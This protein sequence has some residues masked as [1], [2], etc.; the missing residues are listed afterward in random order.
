MQEAPIVLIPA[1]KPGDQFI[2]L[3]HAIMQSGLRVLVVDDGGGDAY[4]AL[5]DE[6]QTLGCTVLRHE[7]NYGKGRALKTGMQAATEL[8]KES[9]GI[10]TADA[11][12]QHTVPDILRIADAMQQHA[13]ALI[14][15]VRLFTG[16]VPLRSRVGNAITRVVTRAISGIRCRD[17]QTGLRGIPMHA[18]PGMLS[19]QGDRYEY[20]MSMLLH[21]RELSLS[22]YEVIIETVYIDDNSG[23]HFHAVRDGARIYAVIFRYFFRFFLSSLISFAVDYALYL[24]L[25]YATHL[26]VAASYAIARAVSSLVNYTINRAVVFK[27]HGGKWSIVRYYAL[28]L[29]LMGA[30]A[31]LADVLNHLL[32]LSPSIIKPLIDFA[33]FF[34]SFTVQ[35]VFV[36]GD[37]KSSPE[38]KP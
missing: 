18:V 31:G 25:L 14:I 10:V 15:G 36:F 21:A 1:Y 29:L 2:P 5:F 38:T 3:C 32:P 24:L 12:G 22:I 28:A 19:I 9:I 35:R 7:I 37:A 6:A 27:Q 13:D 17:T 26:S 4:S 8:Y 20:E 34:I 11:D 16:D 23:S 33:L 30:G